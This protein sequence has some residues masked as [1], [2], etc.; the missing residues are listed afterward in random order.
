MIKKIAF[1][2]IARKGG[3]STPSFFLGS[4]LS[5]DSHKSA[6]LI[7]RGVQAIFFERGF[8]WESSFSKYLAALTHK[9]YSHLQNRHPYSCRLCYL[10]SRVLCKI[11]DIACKGTFPSRQLGSLAIRIPS[12]QCK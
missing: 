9:V 2:T 10:A 8:H 7:R 5:S 4:P 1:V 3:S 12:V 6:N 11:I